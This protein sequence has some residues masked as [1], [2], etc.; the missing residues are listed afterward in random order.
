MKRIILLGI[1]AL[2]FAS[3]VPLK[4]YSKIV[5]TDEELNSFL[6]IQ[7]IYLDINATSDFKSEG[8]ALMT[9]WE[10]DLK[11]KSKQLGQ[12]KKS[13]T[14]YGAIVTGVGGVGAIVIPNLSSDGQKYVGI[15]VSVTGVIIGALELIS[16]TSPSVEDYYNDS[17]D[18]IGIWELS[19]KD[20]S[21]Y[22]EFRKAEIQI[23]KKYKEFAI[24]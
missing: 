19:K 24:F 12:S 16:A 18:I 10:A 3:C 14:T 13:L 20:K 7:S 4:K 2:L 15:G 6:K 11:E 9:K 21:A 1:I 5:V 22:M 23:K 17:Y 8:D